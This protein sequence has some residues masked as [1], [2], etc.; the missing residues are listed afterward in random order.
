MTARTR[1]S[2]AA[3]FRMAL[4]YGF[5][6]F[7]GGYSVLAQPRREASRAARRGAHR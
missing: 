1:I 4:C 5:A 3:V 7:G 2:L 6:G